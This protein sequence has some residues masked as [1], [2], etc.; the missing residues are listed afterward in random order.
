MSLHLQKSIVSNF[1]QGNFPLQQM[2]KTTRNHDQ[3]KLSWG[4]QSQ[5]IYLQNTPIP[6][7][8]EVWGQNDS[9][10]LVRDL[11]RLCF[12]TREAIPICVLKEDTNQHSQ[13]DGDQHT[14]S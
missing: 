10:S 14:R 2:E 9:K 6:K 12:L 1:Y 13:L 8:Q 4:A 11:L 3:S 5:W 7:A